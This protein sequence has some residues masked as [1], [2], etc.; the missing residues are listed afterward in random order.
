[1]TDEQHQG[2][3]ITATVEVVESV[4]PSFMEWF[5]VLTFIAVGLC[6]TFGLTAQAG[7]CL[8]GAAFVYCARVMARIAPSTDHDDV[9]RGPL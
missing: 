1:M 3:E 7:A 9:F 8:L 2:Q 6:L 5:I 4:W